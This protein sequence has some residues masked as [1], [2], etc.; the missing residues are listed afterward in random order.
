MLLQCMT[1]TINSK[2]DNDTVFPEFIVTGAS[3]SISTEVKYLGHFTTD[4]FRNGMDINSQCHKLY[5]QR[6]MLIWKCHI[7]IADQGQSI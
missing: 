4:D 5:A 6:N 2:Y 3:L 7:C 1:I